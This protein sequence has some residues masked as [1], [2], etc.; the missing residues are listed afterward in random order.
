MSLMPWKPPLSVPTPPGTPGGKLGV[1]SWLS[2]AFKLTRV[3]AIGWIVTFIGFALVP[4]IIKIMGGLGIGFISYQLGSM[5]LNEVFQQIQTNFN[6]LP[7]EIIPFV[8]MSKIGEGISIVFGG[9]A[10]K[11]ALMGFTSTQSTGKRRGMI[12]EA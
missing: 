1:V 3:T 7:P 12:W 9:M 6:A 10:A 4:I 8:G 11:L 2:H 5:A